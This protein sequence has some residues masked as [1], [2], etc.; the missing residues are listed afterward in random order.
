MDT[1]VGGFDLGRAELV[2]LAEDG[3]LM[4]RL[5]HG[6]SRRIRPSRIGRVPL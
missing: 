1:V 3:F 5:T 4:A 6:A 2:E